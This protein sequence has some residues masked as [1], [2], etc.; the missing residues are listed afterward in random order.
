EGRLLYPLQF[1]MG[2][3]AVWCADRRTLLLRVWWG[4]T[5]FEQ[6]KKTLPLTP[7]AGAEGFAAPLREA[8]EKRLPRGTLVW[9]AGQ[10]VPPQMLAVVL[11]FADGTGTTPAP[12]KRVK[13]FAVG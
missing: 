1:K 13:T 12:L 4:S 6:M 3:G 9:M 10:S 11:P 5:T 7:R 2:E 8:I